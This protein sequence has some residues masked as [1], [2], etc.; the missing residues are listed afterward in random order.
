MVN[1]QLPRATH[2]DSE[3]CTP[4]AKCVCVE[5]MQNTLFEFGVSIGKENDNRLS[6]ANS[7]VPESSDVVRNSITDTKSSAETPEVPAT[8]FLGMLQASAH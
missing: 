3:L 4:C 5:R 8:C 2:P 7:L 1:R 6:S